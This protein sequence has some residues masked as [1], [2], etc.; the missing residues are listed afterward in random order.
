MRLGTLAVG[1]LTAC[2]LV[3]V[4]GC[5]SLD[6]GSA[7][8]ALNAGRLDEAAADIEA[9]LNRD[10]DNPRIKTLASTIYTQRGVKYYQDGQMIA[11]IDDFHRAINYDSTNATPVDYLGMIAYQRHNWPDAINYGSKAASMSG[12]PEPDYVADAR[13]QQLKVQSGGIRPFLPP[14]SRPPLRMTPNL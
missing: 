13:R 3:A 12:K 9:A 14:G 6:Q 8:T 2:M 11:A 10:P 7:Q 5:A 4:G 1:L